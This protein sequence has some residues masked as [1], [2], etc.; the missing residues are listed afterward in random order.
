MHQI[1][2]GTDT[3]QLVIA[4]YF[5]GSSDWSGGIAYARDWLTPQQF[6]SP[7]GRWKLTQ[8]FNVPGDLPI[9][10]KLIR[11]HIG[12]KNFKYPLCLVD[13]YGWK[14]C[15]DS[16]TDHVA[17]LF[18]HELHHF[19]RYH[20]GLHDREGENSA[21]RWALNRLLQLNYHVTGEKLSRS[22]N[23]SNLARFIRSHLIADPY[24]KFRSLNT[25]DKVLIRYDPRGHYRS[26]IVSVVRPIRKNSKR[27]VVETHDGKQWRW[28]LE[29]VEIM[30]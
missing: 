30:P 16:F 9:V 25:G 5:C 18:S 20:L 10:F 24:K 2:D 8:K 12:M 15:Y 29:W 19:R 6:I 11:L 23:R 22:N 7:R 21:N 3:S 4:S 28:P 17:F 14:L 13:R 26:H 27:I 1:A